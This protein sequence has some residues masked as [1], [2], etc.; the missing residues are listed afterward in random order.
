MSGLSVG[1]FPRRDLVQEFFGTF[2]GSG[3]YFTDYLD[4]SDIRDTRV[5]FWTDS[6][7]SP[8]ACKIE[9]SQWDSGSSS[10]HLIR[11]QSISVSAA[12]GGGYQG[13][14]ELP[15]TGRYFQIILS[16]ADANAQL[17]LTVRMV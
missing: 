3:V 13:Y 17:A 15:L 12:P 10:L 14:A 6:S 2:N 16:S 4:S 7:T 9:E 1:P 8:N 11:T 5:A